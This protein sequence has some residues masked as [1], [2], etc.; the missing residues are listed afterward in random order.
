MKKFLLF[1]FVCSMLPFA[2]MMVWVRC[3]WL[4]SHEMERTMDK[5]IRRYLEDF[6]R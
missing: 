6:E 1:L 4:L 5:A 3:V 2:G